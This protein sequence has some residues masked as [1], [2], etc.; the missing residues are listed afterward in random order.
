MVFF[1]QNI[2]TF[3]KLH[4]SIWIGVVL[5]VCSISNIKAQKNYI[6]NPSFEKTNN[7]GHEY[8]DFSETIFPGVKDW[9]D[10]SSWSSFIVNDSL[11]ERYGGSR[12][13]LYRPYSGRTY[14]R[15]GLFSDDL[16]GAPHGDKGFTSA[17][18][19]DTLKKGCYYQFSFH[20]MPLGVLPLEGPPP[21]NINQWASYFGTTK[22]L[23]V[24]FSPNRLLD[25][26]SSRGTYFDHLN[27]QPQVTLP[28]DTFITDT[29]KYTLVQG[30]FKGND[31]RYMT[32]G[33]FKPIDQIEVLKFIDNK[34][35]KLQDTG[36]VGRFRPMFFIDSLSL[37][38]V[39]PPDTL[40]TSS[41]DTSIC[42]GDSLS[43]YVDAKEALYWQWDDGSVDSLRVI[44]QPGTYWVNAFY[45]CG[46]VLTD[47]IVV[48]AF[49]SLPILSVNDTMVCEGEAI[50]YS[51]PV[52]D[53]SYKL[54]GNAVTGNF[55]ISQ[56]G[57]YRLNASNICESQDYNF[58]VSYTPVN[59]LPSLSLLDTSLCNG[60]EWIVKLPEDFM[61]RLD[62]QLLNAFELKLSERQDYE[63]EVDNGC[64]S[65]HYDFS[66]LDDG[67]DIK[68]SVPNAFT[69]NG[70][71]LN[72]CFEIFVSEYESF[73]LLVFNRWGERV[74]ESNDPTHCWSGTVGGKGVY[75]AHTY[76][77]RVE[78]DLRQQIRYGTVTVLR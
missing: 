60:D 27:I 22:D 45:H 10:C 66:I 48:M 44:D 37:Y 25:T 8:L 52:T 4:R 2:I 72:D 56:A 14:L 7:R 49:S 23:G 62:G 59:D 77:L 13:N 33:F 17:R 46:E 61:Y 31:E 40:L 58:D 28:Q 11:H 50:T 39:S 21:Y 76:T 34:I 29:S 3:S 71:G 6:S 18:L 30:V 57:Q 73:H 9:F 67:C 26:A 32:I 43:L 20:V 41:T 53:V 5:L 65:V 12:V 51:L 47:T 19:L 69:P 35:Y 70:D 42:T 1:D 68:L 24:H 78:K 74:F 64:E 38:Q 63:L 36:I 16:F 55:S 75:G 54:N 15:L